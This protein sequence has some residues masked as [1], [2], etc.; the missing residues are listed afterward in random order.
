MRNAL[1]VLQT[2]RSF[3]NLAGIGLMVQA[4][5]SSM[6][7]ASGRITW[8][9]EAVKQ[10]RLISPAD[11]STGHSVARPLRTGRSSRLSWAAKLAK[12]ERNPGQAEE[13]MR[14]PHFETKYA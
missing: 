6:T 10:A 4:K 1:W 11:G 3:L 8:A 14:P 12:E 9:C 2:M 7:C 13:N 5:R